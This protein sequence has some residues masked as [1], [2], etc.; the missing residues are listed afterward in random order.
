MD[1]SMCANTACKSK[2][3]CIRFTW[4]SGHMQAYQLFAPNEWEDKCK[5]FISNNKSDV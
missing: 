1:I 2:N 3:K 5:N 4:I